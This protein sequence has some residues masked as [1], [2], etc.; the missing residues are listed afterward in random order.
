MAERPWAT[1]EEVKE[2]TDYPSVKK[3]DD[4]K[5]KID[6]TRAEQYVISYTNNKFE[7]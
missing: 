2:Y 4:A 6:I 3:R 1:P 7:E 5:L